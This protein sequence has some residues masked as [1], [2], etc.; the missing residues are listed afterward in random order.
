VVG[1]SRSSTWLHR[2]FIDRLDLEFPLYSD[3]DLDVSSA[4]GVT[5]RALGVSRR[6]RRSC[7]L[8]GTD[9]TIEYRWV[10]EH[11]LDPTRDVPPVSE[12]YD[13]IRDIVDTEDPET[14]GF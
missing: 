2:Q 10:G 1:I 8:A 12:M 11:W 4:F 7:F 3:P 9:G 6:S 5:Y 14:F 13:E